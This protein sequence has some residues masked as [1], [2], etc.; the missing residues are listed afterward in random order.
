MRLALSM[1][2]A[3]L[4]AAVSLTV[5]TPAMASTT[6]SCTSLT[7][8]QLRSGQGGQIPTIGWQTG[9]DNCLLGVGNQSI[10]V[11]RLQYVLR[12]CYSRQIAV[13]G[14]FGP[15]TRT[16]LQYAQRAEHIS[17][18]GVYGPQTRDHPKWMDFYGRCA[19]L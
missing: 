18:D 15:Q 1:S 14:I 7:I 5:S 10:A 4:M 2:I 17:A 12:Y 13:D 9:K 19:R 11:E 6:A 16:A 3:V 8:Y